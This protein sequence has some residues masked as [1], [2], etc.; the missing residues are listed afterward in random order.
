MKRVTG[1]EARI[2]L[3]IPEASP[4]RGFWLDFSKPWQSGDVDGGWFAGMF[5]S[6]LQHDWAL[7]RKDLAWQSG[8]LIKKK[9]PQ[10]PQFKNSS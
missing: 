5:S 7:L 9:N 2:I 4:P 10:C 3:G 6:P 1:V 8:F